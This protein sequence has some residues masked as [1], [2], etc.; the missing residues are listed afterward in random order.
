MAL[1]K[2]IEE[3]TKQR[4]PQTWCHPICSEMNLIVAIVSNYAF[5][6]LV[7]DWSF[8]SSSHVCL[9]LAP[10]FTRLRKHVVTEGHGTETQSC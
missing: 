9:A 3:K 10:F 8:S 5:L 7:F 2:Y 4:F 1:S 6:V